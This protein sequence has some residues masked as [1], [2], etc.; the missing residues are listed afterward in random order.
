MMHFNGRMLTVLAA[1]IFVFGCGQTSE[2]SATTDTNP[3]ATTGS[4]PAPATTTNTALT[5]WQEIRQG[6]ADLQAAIEAGQ[7][8][9]VHGKAVALQAKLKGMVDLAANLPADQLAQLQQRLEA[10]GRLVD[11]LHVSA[12]GGDLSKTKTEFAKFETE[13]HAIEGLLGAGAK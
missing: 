7:L 9:Q 12:D 1:T 3:E 4:E 10:A 2:K 11:A 8:D 13:L 6:E 5:G